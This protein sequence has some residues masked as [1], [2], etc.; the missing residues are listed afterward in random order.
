MKRTLE[1]DWIVFFLQDLYRFND[2]VRLRYGVNYSTTGYQEFGSYA[3]PRTALVWDVTPRDILSFAYGYYT[4]LPDG[5]RTM[6]EFGSDKLGYERSIH[7]ALSYKHSFEESSW[8]QVEPYYKSLFDLAVADDGNSSGELYRSE[9]EGYAKGLDVTYS[10]RQDRLYL[11]G[12]YSYVDS[13]RKIAVNDGTLY[14]FYAEVPHTL[15]LAGSYK[16]GEGWTVSTLAKYT[17]GRPYTP[18]IGTEPTT[19]VID[20]VTVYTPV[21]GKTFSKRLP[22]YFALN[23][24]IAK[25]KLY[26]DDTRLEY[27]FELMN[28]TNHQNVVDIEY[29]ADYSDYEYIYDLPMI[30]WF[31]VTYRF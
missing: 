18:V 26:P 19:Q 1:I 29:E 3:D 24:K 4:A 16:L 28:A 9:G 23:L 25:E 20:G 5:V 31:D 8:L 11:Y 6:K 10:Y 13:R 12:V 27:S 21:Y 17:S 22:E 15:Q 30:P 2:T 7:Y 14:P